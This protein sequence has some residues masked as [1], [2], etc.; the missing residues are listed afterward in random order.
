MT[1]TDLINLITPGTNLEIV[2]YD[3]DEIGLPV[4]EVLYQGIALYYPRDLDTCE[5]VSIDPLKNGTLRIIL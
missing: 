1:F 5:V 4:L 2:V 3:I